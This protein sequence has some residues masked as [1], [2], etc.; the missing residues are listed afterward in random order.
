MIGRYRKDG[1]PNAMP[2]NNIILV[3]MGVFFLWF[4]WFG[5]NPGSTLS[6]MN[7]DIATIAVTT[8]LAGAAGAITAMFLTWFMSRKADIAMTCNGALAGLVAITAGC[9]V[10]SPLSSIIIGGLAGVIVVYAVYFF[11]SLRIDDPVGAISVHGVCGAFGTICVGLFAEKTY[12]GGV[13]GLFFG[14]GFTQLITQT[15]GVV[16]VFAFVAL[17]AF[18]MFKLIQL[19][20]GLRVTP[21]E[22]LRGLDQGE[23]GMSAYPDFMPTYDPMRR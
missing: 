16:S 20:I 15:I 17:S 23:H 14:G 4:G 21:E 1:K 5:F 6:G 7:P 11:D 2:G 19:T 12:S 10:V 13:N 3:V 18:L 22:E 9:A 8:N